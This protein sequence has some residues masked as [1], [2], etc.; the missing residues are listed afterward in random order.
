MISLVIGTDVPFVW[1]VKANGQ[2]VLL[3]NHTVTLYVENS[4]GSFRLSD[5]IIEGDQVRA[6]YPGAIQTRLG[7]HSLI[8]R[9]NEGQKGMATVSVQNAFKLV[10]WGKDAG[11][12]NEGPVQVNALVF[13]SEL[14]FGNA[15]ADLSAY[16]TK[17]E[18]EKTYLKK[19]EGGESYDDTEVKAELARL[20]KNKADKSELT[21]LSTQVS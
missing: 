2:P 4:R 16:L 19:G 8:L 18:A 1:H 15:E 7:E 13:E 17:E 21:E 9:L 10:A 11:G 3:D 20:E 6:T 14:S 5:L 12:E